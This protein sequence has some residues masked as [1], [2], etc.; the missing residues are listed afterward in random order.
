VRR[1]FATSRAQ[2]GTTTVEFA[3]VGLALFIVLFGTIEVSRM[4]VARAMLEES[5]RRGARLAAVCPVNDPGIQQ[6]AVF[7]GGSQT[8]IVR[9]LTT[10]NL[11]VQYLD[12][13]GNVLANPAGA[14]TAIR[15]VRVTLQG[16]TLPLFIPLLDVI[17]TPARVSSTLPAESLGVTPTAVTPC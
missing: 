13:A 12:A 8:A 15:F 16:F 17:L 7:P 11:Q 6:R 4:M 5:V 14:F 10:N 3:I 9:G 2:G 1:P